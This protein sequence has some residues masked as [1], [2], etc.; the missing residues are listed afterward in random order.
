M[1]LKS[2]ERAAHF[3][4]RVLELGQL[5]ALGEGIGKGLAVEPLEFG[6]GVESFH[7]RGP[8]GHAKMDDPFGAMGKFSGWIAF[9][10]P[11]RG[12]GA[13]GAAKFGLMQAGQRQ[14]TQAY[15][16]RPRKV[17]RLTLSWIHAGR[18]AGSSVFMLQ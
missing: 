8:A 16:D 11:F 2:V 14:A 12:R 5:L 9:P 6:F 17:R 7:V 13:G 18:S 10:A 4:H 15:A 3:E 1:L